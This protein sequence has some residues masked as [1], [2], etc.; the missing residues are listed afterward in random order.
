[1]N[2]EYNITESDYVDFQLNYLEVSDVLKKSFFKT[3]II[4]I[5]FYGFIFINICIYFRNNILLALIAN[6]L[7]IIFASLQIITYEKRTKNKI[8][9]RLM[10]V[11]KKDDMKSLF[12]K[13]R[14]SIDNDKLSYFEDARGSVFSLSEIKKILTS[15][16]SLFLYLDEISA[17]I[18]P[19]RA[20]NSDGEIRDFI[21]YIESK[22]GKSFL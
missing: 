18:I 4:L 7:L 1:M 10:K 21:K 17:I 12:G 19:K 16:N 11:I 9:K 2:I 22:T 20:F 6:I 8:I 14:V 3:K 13:K 15:N 5:F